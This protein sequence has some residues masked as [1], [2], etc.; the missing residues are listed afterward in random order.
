MTFAAGPLFIGT[1]LVEGAARP[2]YSQP[3][4]PVSSL[5]LGPRGW[6]QTANFALAGALCLGF[7]ADSRRAPPVAGVTSTTSA[8]IGAAAVDLIGAAGRGFSINHSDG[9][10]LT[11]R[12]GF[13]AQMKTD[14]FSAST[15]VTL[16]KRLASLRG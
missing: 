8:L 12:D 10:G 13:G 14:E 3:R 1:F 9:A 15:A 6:M 16:R 4:H 7:A 2:D 11:E 5:A